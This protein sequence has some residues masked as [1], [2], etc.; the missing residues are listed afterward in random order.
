MI[1]SRHALKLEIHTA[2]EQITASAVRALARARAQHDAGHEAVQGELTKV[3]QLRQ[4]VE[5]LR[6]PAMTTRAD[7]NQRGA[8]APGREGCVSLDATR[9]FNAVGMGRRPRPRH[10]KSLASDRSGGE[11]K[12]IF[13]TEA[14]RPQ[15]P[16]GASVSPEILFGRFRVSLSL[17]FSVSLR[18]CVECFVISADRAARRAWSVD[19]EPPPSDS[20]ENSV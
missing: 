13:E 20:P 1:K 10:V 4:A 9:T 6:L 8:D 2:L 18:L 14:Q 15:S 17:R 5:R 12:R 11:G 19:E 16:E 7:A 3:E